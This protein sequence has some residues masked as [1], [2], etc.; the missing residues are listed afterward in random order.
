M[1]CKLPA[2]QILHGGAFAECRVLAMSLP[3]DGARVN[4]EFVPTMQHFASRSTRPIYAFAMQQRLGR[5]SPEPVVHGFNNRRATTRAIF[6]HLM[7][8][9]KPAESA[10]T[11]HVW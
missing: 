11:A 2:L 5:L 6:S 3:L 7:R 4:G 9:E 1:L 10:Q 8:A